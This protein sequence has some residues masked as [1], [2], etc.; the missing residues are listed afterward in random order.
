M[1][2]NDPPKKLEWEEPPPR[3][4]RK[5]PGSKW[6]PIAKA[7]K[8]RPGQWACIG[9]DIPTSIIPVINDAKLKCFQ[10]AGAFESVSRN[11]TARWQADVYARYVGDEKT[12]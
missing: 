9:R 6:D 5:Q 2:Y 12:E 11:H 10:P 7:L 3:P 8:S 4:P 1:G